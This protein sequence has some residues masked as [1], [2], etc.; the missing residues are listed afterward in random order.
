MRNNF[1][2]VIHVKNLQHAVD[3]AQ[4]A[5]A[6]NADGIFLINMG[7]TT[8]QVLQDAFETLCLQY[9]SNPDFSVGINYL[10]YLD[11]INISLPP[12]TLLW[13]DTMEGYSEEFK[14]L[15]LVETKFYAPFMFKYQNPMNDVPLKE[16]ENI[17]DV[18]TTSG[19]RTGIP[20]SL[21]KIRYI[22]NQVSKPIAIAS[23]ISAENVRQF[24][25]YV[26]DFLVGTSI[27]YHDLIPEKVM[28]L[29]GIIHE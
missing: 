5:F 9:D 24:K 6:A 21:E 12:K 14:Q 29:E 25:P 18:I 11:Q 23:G 22:H 17:C 8:K 7:D 28:E 15:S 1:Y 27:G 16:L 2:P 19:D 10:T 4:V 3:N 26:R 20:P 13:S